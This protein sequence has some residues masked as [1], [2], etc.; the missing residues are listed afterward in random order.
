[1]TLTVALALVAAAVLALLALQAWWKARRLKP[2]AMT[3]EETVS[4]RFEPALEGA[5]PGADALA[6]RAFADTRPHGLADAG[7][8]PVVRSR[9]R[10]HA[11]QRRQSTV[12]HGSAGFRAHREHDQHMGSTARAIRHTRARSG[13]AVREPG[14][15]RQR[16][17]RISTQRKAFSAWLIH[18]H[19]LASRFKLI[20]D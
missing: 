5:G 18:R 6:S 7:V 15:F 11:L 10:A 20:R 8:A 17:G 4:S 14:G 16:S 13:P 12:G 2:R 9:L 1:M 19:P 3:L